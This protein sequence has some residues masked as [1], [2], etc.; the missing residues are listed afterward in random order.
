M[1]F[2]DPIVDERVALIKPLTLRDFTPADVDDMIELGQEMH[3]ESR[4]RDLP[5]DPLR[6]RALGSEIQKRP[7][8]YFA[9]TVRNSD[10]EL[11]GMMVGSTVFYFFCEEVYATDMAVYVKKS[12]RGGAAALM[13]LRSFFEWAA[14]VEAKEVLL[15]TNTLINPE[16]TEKLYGRLGM[17]RVGSLWS[18]RI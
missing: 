2:V 13:L 5:Y 1:T 10:D 17:E 6:L 3:E 7:F 9:K 14:M 18:R 12:K 4:F 16:A 8:K 11:Y 15:G